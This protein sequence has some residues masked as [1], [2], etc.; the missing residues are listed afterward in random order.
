MALYYGAL[1]A[2]MS[3]DTTVCTYPFTCSVQTMHVQGAANNLLPLNKSLEYNYFLD[4]CEW[5]SFA[6]IVFY[7]HCILQPLLRAVLYNNFVEAKCKV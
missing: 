7:R 3:P 6:H 4:V 1:W 2:K 5:S